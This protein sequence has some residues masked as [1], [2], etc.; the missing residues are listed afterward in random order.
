MLVIPNVDDAYDAVMLND[1]V[2]ALFAHDAVE[3]N[4]AVCAVIIYD[5]VTALLAHDAVAMNDAV[6]EAKTYD[7]VFAVKTKDA[8]SDVWT[9][10]AVIELFDQEDV[11]LIKLVTVNIS[12][13]MV[14][15]IPFRESTDI[16][17]QVIYDALIMDAVNVVTDTFWPVK[18]D[19]II[20][21]RTYDAVCAVT[22]K[23]EVTE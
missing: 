22:T 10:E 8:V 16:L 11:P 6:W 12:T 9:Y 21:G 20:D 13:D 19:K 17:L 5:E 23:D 7:A 2:T 18:L 14:V 15:N 1:E 3:M 4:D